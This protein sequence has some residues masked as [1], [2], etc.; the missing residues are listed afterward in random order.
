ML[1]GKV[2]KVLLD[3]MFLIDVF[4]KRVVVDIVGLL[5]FFIDKGNCF[6]LMLVD[7]VIRFL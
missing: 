4:F 7:Y 1:K 2:S 5:Y 3:S 6:I